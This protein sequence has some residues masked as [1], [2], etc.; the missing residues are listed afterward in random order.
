MPRTEDF[1]VLKTKLEEET[2]TFEQVLEIAN[3]LVE[4]VEYWEK[5]EHSGTNFLT[6]K[7]KES[8]ENLKASDKMIAFDGELFQRTDG[9]IEARDKQIERLK[10][11]LDIYRSAV[12]QIGI[13]G[14]I[15]IKGQYEKAFYQMLQIA[16][17][18]VKEVGDSE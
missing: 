1:E 15:D 4:H 16:S 3:E 2:L 11:D 8:E 9:M 17:D 7:L 6:K 18:A 10:I 14:H 12:D 5:A 13:I